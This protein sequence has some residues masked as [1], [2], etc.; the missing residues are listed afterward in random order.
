V[1]AYVVVRVE[2]TDDPL[3]ALAAIGLALTG[4]R[5]P[6]DLYAITAVAASGKRPSVHAPSVTT[7]AWRPEERD[8]P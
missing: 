6:H 4:D 2:G 7:D 1:T 8:A 3:G 5:G